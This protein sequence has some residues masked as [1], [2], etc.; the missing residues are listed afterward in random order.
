M[1]FLQNSVHFAISSCLHQ[2]HASCLMP[3]WYI[4]VDSITLLVKKMNTWATVIES[5]DSA[6]DNQRLFANFLSSLFKSN[7][8][9]VNISPEAPGRTRTEIRARKHDRLENP[10]PGNLRALTVIHSLTNSQNYTQIIS[11]PF[12]FYEEFFFG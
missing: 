1:A 8:K 6:L 3:H 12:N 9:F 2:F 7:S 10:D 4:R 11:K 5:G